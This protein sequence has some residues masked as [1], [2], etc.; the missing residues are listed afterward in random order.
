MLSKNSIEKFLNQDR[1]GASPLPGLIVLEE[2]DSTN[3]YAK[4][5]I[6][7][8]DQ[9]YKYSGVAVAASR[10]TSGRGR[11]GRSFYSP[12][13]TGVYLTVILP[14]KYTEILTEKE[15]FAG[16]VTIT[17]AVAAVRAVK[18]VSGKDASVKPVNDIIID[19]KKV[20][21]I[22]AEGV[23]CGGEPAGLICGIGINVFDPENGFPEDIAS[24][25]GSLFGR[26][27]GSCVNTEKIR[28]EL[29]G[30]FI[31]GF[32]DLIC[33]VCRDFEKQRG[34]AAGDGILRSVLSEYDS[35]L[36]RI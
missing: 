28:E 19:G 13:G 9:T 15:D 10:Q 17:A 25:A 33:G 22:L 12:E 8:G 18:A 11:L 27:P 30:R 2:T 36:L 1:R 21:G 29:A 31:S 20:A 4:R 24:R 7:G 32:L 35:K 3:Q 23:F 26:F 34:G 16:T 14:E 6:S 5:L